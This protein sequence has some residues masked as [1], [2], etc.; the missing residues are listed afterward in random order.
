MKSL[1]LADILYFIRG[2]LI[3]GNRNLLIKNVAVHPKK[4]KQNTLYFDFRK[5]ALKLRLLEKKKC[6]AII[7]DKP[8]LITKKN[9]G[10]ITVVKVKDVKSAY[11]KFV[12]YYRNLFK[13]PVIGVTG[14]VGKTTTTDMIAKILSPK[15]RVTSTR[16]GK[17]GLRHNLSYLLSF[18]G[19][20]EAAVFELGVTH[21]GC[22][23]ESC[24]YFQPKVGV[25]LNI[26]V[27]HLQGCKTMDNYIKA[28]LEILKGMKNKGTL[29]INTDDEI[30]KEIDFSKFN[31]EIV[32]IGLTQGCHFQGENISYVED[33][34]T[35]TLNFKNKEYPVFI[36]G[37][38]KHNVYNALAS[39]AASHALGIRIE[40]AINS[41]A[42]FKHMHQHLNFCK[43]L[44]GSTIIDDTWNCNPPGIRAGLQVLQDKA[45]NRKK[46]AV[47]GYMPLLGETGYGQYSKIG[48]EAVK[49]KI[50]LLVIIGEEAKAIGLRALELGMTNK[51]VYFCNTEDEINNV[52]YPV[53]NEDC[54][55]LLKFP[56]RRILI[57]TP[58]YP[59]FKACIKLCL[60]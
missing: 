31:G 35:F 60:G 23:T 5:S 8:T 22:I 49:A 36:P 25:L 16:D 12:K 51:E 13:I 41:L 42:T 38:G 21:P 30:L 46:I 15:Y 19:R 58:S 48:E 52:L 2:S 26:G 6:V 57:N 3:N 18:S 45:H 55:V 11:W 4:I 43:G 32:L 50:D 20:T 28:K 33:G 37:Y 29:I 17:N 1:L 9:Q 7:T 10:N 44:N 56:Y 47:I 39:I 14:T 24:T 34:I 27:Y 53:L 54:L 40:E 59:V